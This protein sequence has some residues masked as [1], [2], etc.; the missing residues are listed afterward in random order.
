M[1]EDVHPSPR[2]A[3]SNNFLVVH[4]LTLRKALGV[5]GITLPFVMVVGENLRDWLAPHAAPI[6]R[7]VIE[8]SL[9]AYFH[10]GMRDVFVGSLCT[11]GVFLL[12]YKGY[13]RRDDLV[14]GAAG[15]CALLVALFPT[16]EQSREA[17]DTGIRPPDSVTFFSG[18]NAPDPA[19][20]GWIHFGS[21]ALL[22]GL[23]AYM[24]IVLFTRSDTPSPT[25]R[26]KTR[27]H[28][29]RICGWV[30]LA[31]IAAIAAGKLLFDAD[32]ER[33]TRFVFW[34]ESIAVVVFGISWLTKGEMILKDRPGE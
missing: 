19:V 34:F 30:I 25:K 28:V 5:I 17:G 24:S 18:P 9:S 3:E 12:C 8:L 26:K 33:R 2:V 31:C 27:N 11:I 15:A 20:V 32:F 10:T 21:A 4:F 22:F 13:E 16:T 14:A 6:G 23:L 29:Y 1:A 7:Q